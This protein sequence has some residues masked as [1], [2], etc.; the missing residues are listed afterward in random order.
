MKTAYQRPYTEFLGLCEL[1]ARRE[2]WQPAANAAGGH[3]AIRRVAP[4]AVRPAR[5]SEATVRSPRN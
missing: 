3:S 1:L 5:D 4:N 2:D